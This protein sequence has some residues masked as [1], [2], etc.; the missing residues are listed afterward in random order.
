MH[1]YLAACLAVMR[2][3]ADRHGLVLVFD[4]I[5]TG[6]AAPARCSPPTRPGSP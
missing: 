3:V 1:I 4:E 5:A 2:E 6:F